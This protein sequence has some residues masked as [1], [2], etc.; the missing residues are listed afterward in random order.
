MGNEREV[1][2][3]ML[4]T[5]GIAEHNHWLLDIALDQLALGRAHLGLAQLADG[6][7]RKTV[8]TWSQRL[9]RKPRWSLSLPL[10]FLA[11]SVSA[12]QLAQAAEWLH[13]AVDGL[14][15]AGQQDYLP[16][17]LL[18]R[19]AWAR[20]A[21]QFDRAHRDL[22]EARSI[23]ER[24]EM[25]LHLTDYHLESARLALAEGEKDIARNHYDKARQL[26]AETGYHRRDGELKEIEEQLAGSAKPGSASILAG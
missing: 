17:G 4:Q 6:T 15:Q 16:R 10:P 26:I 14:R 2:A 1:R 18:A 11:P 23:A 21:Q 20:M 19:A 3:R 8:A 5:I 12:S 25:R 22:A 13:R 9:Y 7:F 24:G